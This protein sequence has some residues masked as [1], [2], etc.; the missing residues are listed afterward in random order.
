VTI[1]DIASF[2][3]RST[4][5]GP[6]SALSACCSSQA[7]TATARHGPPDSGLGYAATVCHDQDRRAVDSSQR[8][9]CGGVTW[10]LTRY[11]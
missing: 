7:S 1:T 5:S 4:K 3:L 9:W 6:T 10:I 2:Y 8:S 11:G